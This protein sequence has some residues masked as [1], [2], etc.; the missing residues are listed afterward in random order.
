MVPFLLGSGIIMIAGAIIAVMR[1]GIRL[2]SHLEP[3]TPTNKPHLFWS[4][5]VCLIIVGV[6]LL[7]LPVIVWLLQGRPSE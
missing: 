6:L 5:V 1:A 2:E 4:I 3:I 7:F